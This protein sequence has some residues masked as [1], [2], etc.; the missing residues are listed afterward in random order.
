M[1]WVK[2]SSH[3]WC[4][5]FHIQPELGP[6]LER[7]PSLYQYGLDGFL[8][9]EL[10]GCNDNPHQHFKV[11]EGSIRWYEWWCWF[12]K[13]GI[14]QFQVEVFQQYRAFLLFQM[15]LLPRFNL[16]S[17]KYKVCIYLKQYF[18]CAKFAKMQNLKISCDLL[19]R[20]FWNSKKFARKV[21]EKDWVHQ[22][23]TLDSLLLQVAHKVAGFFKK[24][25]CW[26]KR[27]RERE[28]KGF[29][30]DKFWGSL[31]KQSGKSCYS[32]VMFLFSFKFLMLWHVW[33]HPKRDLAWNGDIV[34]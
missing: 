15:S 8:R 23:Y 31:D 11:F 25:P 19:N 29:D 2:S 4:C 27:E 9:M 34:F 26:E 5:I 7:Y 12:I 24:S 17:N 16:V 28:E 1:K 3:S 14:Q 21:K 6:T 13:G 32:N 33:Q 22:V 10:N 30:L 18:L 20:H